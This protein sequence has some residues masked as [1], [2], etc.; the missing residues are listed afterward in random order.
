[1]RL[2]WLSEEISLLRSQKE[3]E[4]RDSAEISRMV[5]KICCDFWGD[6]H[7][8]LRLIVPKSRAFRRLKVIT[9]QLKRR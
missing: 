9:A 6:R 1:V 3:L 4:K 7:A 2:I 8:F 5:F